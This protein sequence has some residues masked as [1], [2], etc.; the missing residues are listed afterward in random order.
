M[1][2]F[3]IFRHAINTRQSGSSI[4]AIKLKL[5]LLWCKQRF[6]FLEHLS[7]RHLMQRT[8]IHSV[9]SSPVQTL[10]LVRQD[11]TR[12]LQYYGNAENG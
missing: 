7:D 9:A 2:Q 8:I 1:S 11:D 4:P 6:E 10:H 3:S 12:H 5:L